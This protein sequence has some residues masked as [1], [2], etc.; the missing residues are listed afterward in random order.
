MTMIWTSAGLTWPPQRPPVAPLYG[1]GE[2][3]GEV[4]FVGIGVVVGVGKGLGE[5]EF[6]A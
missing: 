5:G 4:I 1:E 2:E 3:G 6:C